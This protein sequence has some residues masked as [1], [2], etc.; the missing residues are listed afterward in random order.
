MTR[1][2]LEIN[3]L[4]IDRPKK[5]WKIYFVIIT[6][7]PTEPDKMVI[8]T[9]PNSPIRFTPNLD[10]VFEFGDDSAGSEGLLILRREMPINRDLN[11]HCYVRHSRSDVRDAGDVL[12]DIQSGLGANVSNVVTDILGTTNPWLVI[13]KAALPLIGKIL[14]NVKDREM[15]FIS[16]YERFGSEFEQDEEIDREKIGGFSKVV[17]TWAVDRE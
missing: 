4:S 7:H 11:V 9:I 8:T 2:R 15:G 17:Y 14:I 6:E 5:R 12:N 13:A 1:V 16:M 10:N 3:R